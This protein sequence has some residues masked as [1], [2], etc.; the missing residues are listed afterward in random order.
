MSIATPPTFVEQQMT[1]DDLFSHA[2]AKNYE[3][4][5]GRLLELSLSGLSSKVAARL[6]YL[7]SAFVAKSDL[8]SIYGC[9]CGY[10]C[11]DFD[12]QQVRKPDVSFIASGR[13]S[14]ADEEKGYIRIAPDLVVE[15]ISPN[16]LYHDV[17]VKVAE[18][19]RAGV[20]LV[21]LIDP[22]ARTGQVSR[23]DGTTTRLSESDSFDGVDV[24]PGFK[25]TIADT[26]PKPNTVKNND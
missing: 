24:I 12:D 22:I 17:E 15:V 14:E 10:Q 26:I 20:R 1:A 4:V 9:D 2:E 6:I 3:L 7:L 13:I 11:F 19:L 18:Y 5:G 16:D 21:W 23:P 25:C 8:G